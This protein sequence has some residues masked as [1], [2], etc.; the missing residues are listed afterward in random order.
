KSGQRAGCYHCG[1]TQIYV[2]VAIAHATLEISIGRADRGLAFLHQTATQ[3]DTGSAPGRQRDRAR[4]HQSLPITSRFG[5]G[6][7]FG[8]GRSQIKFYTGSDA[9]T[10]SSPDSMLIL[11]MIMR[12]DMRRFATPS[13]MNSTP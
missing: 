3:T 12:A 8:A 5:P 4:T 1:R 7:N 9:A 11:E 2:R 10:A 6:L 13:P